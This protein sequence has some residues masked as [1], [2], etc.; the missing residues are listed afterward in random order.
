MQ[1]QAKPPEA[2]RAEFGAEQQRPATE[3]DWS[4][5]R[6]SDWSTRRMSA[7]KWQCVRMLPYG[8]KRISECYSYLKLKDRITGG[9]QTLYE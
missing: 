3:L 2:K 5:R 1:L 9:S 4:T 6:M 8:I 7:S